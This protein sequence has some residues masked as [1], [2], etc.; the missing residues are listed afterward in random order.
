M[1]AIVCCRELKH[2]ELKLYS[3]SGR[4]LSDV[5]YPLAVCMGALLQQYTALGVMSAL[6]ARVFGFPCGHMEREFAA[7]QTLT[8]PYLLTCRKA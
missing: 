1:V 8:E 7:I 6:R 3:V 4:F 5:C 2:E